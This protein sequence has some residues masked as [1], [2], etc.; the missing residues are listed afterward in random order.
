MMKLSRFIIFMAGLIVLSI[1][2]FG[3]HVYMHELTHV[4]IFKYYGCEAEVEW[5]AFD[6]GALAATVAGEDCQ[7]T[8]EMLLAHSINEVVGYNFF[9][10]FIPLTLILNMAIFLFATKV[11]WFDD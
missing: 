6:M 4:Q 5:F 7:F 1:F 8:D 3:T 10:V 9:V 2:I 11:G